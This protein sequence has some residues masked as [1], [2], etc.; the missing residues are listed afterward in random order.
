MIT[1]AAGFIGS[2]LVER[3]LKEDFEVIGIDNFLTGNPGNIAPF[4]QHPH[5]KFLHYNVANFIYL[6]GKVDLVLHFACP[7]SPVDYV[8]FPIQTLKVNSLGTL[9]TIGFAKAKKARYVFASTSETY[10]DPLEHPQK[11]SYWG[12]VNSLGPRAVYDEAKRF[13]EAMCM[14]YFREHRVDVRLARIFNTYGPRMRK[15]DGRIIPNFINQALED[16]PCSIYGNG[17]QTRSFCYIDDLVEGIWKFS[18]K[19]GLAG[20]AINLGNPLEFT[21]IETAEKIFRTLNKEPRYEFISLPQDDPKKRCPDIAKAR[22]IL[23]WRPDVSFD[24]GIKKSI[25]YFKGNGANT[26]G[27]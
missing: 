24:D 9:N 22:A 3:F 11:E 25:S 21:V 2:H 4:F 14:A 23:G 8:N 18:I 27:K 26:D 7:A 12:N 10:G 5:F 1:G 20:E 6:D 19:D 13:S 16:K 15:N 17:K